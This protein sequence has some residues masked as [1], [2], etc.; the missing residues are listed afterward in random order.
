MSE[1][2]SEREVSGWAIGGL[3]F[4]ATMMILNGTF[5]AFQGLAAII[6]DEFFVRVGEYAFNVDVTTWGW[7]HLILGIVVAVAGFYLFTGSATAGV[8]AII[9]ASLSALSNFFFIPYYPFWSMLIIAIA[10]FVI[11]AVTRAGVLR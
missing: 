4:A 6:N 10:F 7:I 11:W 9:L 8:I 2:E 1:Y 3:V 5:Q